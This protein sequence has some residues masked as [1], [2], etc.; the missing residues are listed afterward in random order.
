MGAR[1]RIIMAG[2]AIAF[3]GAPLFYGVL[4]GQL[5]P[6]ITLFATFGMINL[7][8]NKYDIGNHAEIS[9]SGEEY[10]DLAACWLASNALLIACLELVIFT[11]E[12]LPTWQAVML[13]IAACA[14]STV[15]ISRMFYGRALTEEYKDLRR[16]IKSMTKK[17]AMSV[18][19]ENLPES[20]YTAIFFVDFE[21]KDINYVADVILFCSPRTV[22]SYRRA[23]YEKLKRLYRQ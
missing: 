3:N 12:A 17:E 19:S 10:K 21:C 15:S 9:S 13:G 8:L 20:E 1:R 23:G 14:L 18:L 22:S 16:K 11:G 4:R 7:S 6:M 2:L 5:V